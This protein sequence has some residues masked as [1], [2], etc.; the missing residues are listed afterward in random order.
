MAFSLGKFGCLM[1]LL[2][3]KGFLMVGY[4][5]GYG[6]PRDVEQAKERA[7]KAEQEKEKLDKLTQLTAEKTKLERE[8]R[9]NAVEDAERSGD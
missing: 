6:G 5:R 7:E 9:E 3:R 2:H 8:A 4:Q 1:R